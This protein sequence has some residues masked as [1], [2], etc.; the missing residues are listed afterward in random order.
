MKRYWFIIMVSACAA[1]Q[2]CGDN[3]AARYGEFLD[4]RAACYSVKNGESMSDDWADCMVG[5]EEWICHGTHECRPLGLPV[6]LQR[7]Q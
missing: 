2:N 4:S 7:I 6:K 1:H 5:S 3:A